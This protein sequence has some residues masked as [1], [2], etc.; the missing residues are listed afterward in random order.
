[1]AVKTDLYLGLFAFQKF[2]MYKDLEANAQV[3]TIH[4]LIRQLITPSGTQLG[5]L[6]GEIQSI[7]II[8]DCLRSLTDARKAHIE[9]SC[10]TGATE[11]CAMRQAIVRC[12]IVGIGS[13]LLASSGAKGI[14]TEESRATLRGLQGVWV[15]VDN[16]GLDVEQAGLTQNQIQTDVELR[17]RKA[18]IRILTR[19]ETLSIPGR[20]WLYVGVETHESRGRPGLYPFV[21]SLELWQLVYLARDPNVATQAPT[22]SHKSILGMTGASHLREVRDRVVVMVDV[23]INAYLAVNPEQAGRTLPP[24]QV[25]PRS[26]GR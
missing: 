7:E 15:I 10:C 20:P 24:S 2:V 21:L 9:R 13:L 4:R 16:L 12:V 3:L 11:E 17:L 5:G 1:V 8:Y 18:G 25:S 22:W 14:D 26:K 19:Q 23:F 6:P